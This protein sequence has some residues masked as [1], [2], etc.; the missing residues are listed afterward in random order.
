M[1]FLSPEARYYIATKA[2]KQRIDALNRLLDKTEDY[3]MQAMRDEM[4]QAGNLEPD[5]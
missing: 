3:E 5:N 1:A 4:M 2:E